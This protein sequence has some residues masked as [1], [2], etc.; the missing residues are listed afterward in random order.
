MARARRFAA[1]GAATAFLVAGVSLAVGLAGPVSADADP[2]VPG[3]DSTCLVH[4]PLLCDDSSDEPWSG[5]AE[6]GDTWSSE[7][8]HD[9]SWTNAPV[10]GDPSSTAPSTGESW[11]SAP[12]PTDSWPSEAMPPW[13]PAGEDEHRVPRGHPETGGGGL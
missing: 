1:A 11:S 13:R 7:P 9:D 8:G 10:P 4:L 3:T 12:G 6:P 2:E 5:D